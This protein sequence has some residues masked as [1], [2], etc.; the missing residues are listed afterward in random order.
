MQPD[1]IS[2]LRDTPFLEVLHLFVVGR[3]GGAPVVDER[4]NVLG[5]LSATD[6]LRV[7]DQAC[8]EDLD[9]EP[10]REG[11]EA[12]TDDAEL[13]E[14]LSRLKAIDVV[15]PDAVW[16]APSTSAARV[17]QLMRAEGIHRV[18][19]G[20]ERRLAGILTAFDLVKAVEH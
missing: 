8:D 14:R 9:P 20:D 16:V 15:T 2:I 17:A 5:M 10:P 12:R 11:S 4:G 3:I 13:P 1:P 6:L 18:L 19:V 7:V